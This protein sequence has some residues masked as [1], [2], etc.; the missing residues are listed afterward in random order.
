MKKILIYF[1][2]GVSTYLIFSCESKNPVTVPVFEDGSQL[3]NSTPVPEISR[4][5]I[6]GIYSVEIG[7]EFFG[8]NVVI[9]WSG[10]SFSIFTGKNFTYFVLKSGIVGSEIVFEGYW[11]YAQDSNTGLTLLTIKPDE[12]SDELILGKE[13]DKQ[14]TI[15]GSFGNENSFSGNDLV[16]RYSRPLYER[17]DPFYIIAHRGGGR[18]LDQ[19]SESENSLG[20]MQLAESYGANSIEID[21]RLT[22]DGIPIIFHDE[23]LS[24]RLVVGEFAVGPINNYTYAHLLTLCKLKNGEPIPTLSQALET[25][26]TKTGLSLVWLDIKDPN[27]VSSAIKLQKEY[28]IVSEAL[29]RKVEILIGMPDEDVVEEF[30]KYGLAESTPSL[31]EIDFDTVLKTD[32]QVWAPAWTHGPMTEDVIRMQSLGKKVFFWTLDRPEFINIFLNEGR[33]DGI[34]SNYP[35]IVAYEYF[36]Q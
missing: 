28:L 10:N 32:S 19:L 35:S 16:L 5:F 21:V 36:I 6:N 1:L 23:N 3:I 4:S 8:K 30:L 13:P 31:C 14:I 25:V 33:V 7:S 17:S 9:H 12:G 20:I 2:I 18:N 29:G 22:K 27:A 26:I 15:R 34:L 24:S 11:K